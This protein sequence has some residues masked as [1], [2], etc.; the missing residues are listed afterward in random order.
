MELL[1]L[2]RA[3]DDSQT[4]GNNALRAAA[5]GDW[6]QAIAQLHAA[7]EKCGECDARAQLH[8]DLGLVYCQ[9]GDLKNGESELLE[10]KK[11]IPADKDIARALEMIGSGTR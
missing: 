5:S 3:T 6:P 4:I 1:S 2:E 9:S 7:I 10:A 11:L 8:K